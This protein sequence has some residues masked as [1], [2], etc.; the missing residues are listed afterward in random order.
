MKT[1][2]TVS[3]PNAQQQNIRTQSVI[4]AR[5]TCIRYVKCWHTPPPQISTYVLRIQKQDAQR[6]TYTRKMY[7]VN[8]LRK[9][10][11]GVRYN[12]RMLQRTVI[13]NKIRML[14]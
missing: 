13:I 7:G 3:I 5:S 11:I 12:E 10:Y 1:C 9:K 4:F 6:I 14:Q 8:A 2:N